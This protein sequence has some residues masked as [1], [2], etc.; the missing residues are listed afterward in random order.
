MSGIKS[1]YVG[2]SACVRVKW[3]ESKLFRIDIGVRQGC[4]MSTW[5]FY[6]YMD[7]VMKEVKMGMGMRGVRF[8]EDGRE[9]RLSGLLYV[10]DLFYVVSRRR[11]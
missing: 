9:W 5:I 7:A 1:M 2:S 11:T 10:D 6:V 4:I 8:L 3:G